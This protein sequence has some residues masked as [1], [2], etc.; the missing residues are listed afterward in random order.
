[1]NLVR[2]PTLAVDRVEQPDIGTLIGG[3]ISVFATPAKKTALSTGS[4]AFLWRMD[5]VTNL[6]FFAGDMMPLVTIVGIRTEIVLH[7]KLMQI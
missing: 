7:K 2:T 6:F 5:T 1:M 3:L 4:S